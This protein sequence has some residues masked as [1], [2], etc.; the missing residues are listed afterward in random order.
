MLLCTAMMKLIA[1]IYF[2]D[3]GPIPDLQCASEFRSNQNSLFIIIMNLDWAMRIRGTCI[4]GVNTSLHCFERSRHFSFRLFYIRILDRID[5]FLVIGESRNLGV[6]NIKNKSLK[7]SQLEHSGL[8][9]NIMHR[10]KHG[11]PCINQTLEAS[12]K[13]LLN[14]KRQSCFWQRSRQIGVHSSDC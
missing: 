3:L 1:F 14:N 4:H 10:V 11:I 6:G 9:L 8:R 12:L 2:Q 13:N 7:G 5:S